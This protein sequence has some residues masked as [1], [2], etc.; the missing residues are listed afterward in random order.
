LAALLVAACLFAAAVWVHSGLE[1]SSRP[2]TVERGRLVIAP[3]G[4]V[5]RVYGTTPHGAVSHVKAGWQDPL[6]AALAGAG[7]VLFVAGLV[8]ARPGPSPS[9]E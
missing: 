3:G 5:A 2:P 9:A 4:A 6:A 7:A 1:A 8:S